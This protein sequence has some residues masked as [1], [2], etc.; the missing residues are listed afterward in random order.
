[1]AHITLRQL[2]FFCALAE[3]GSF[4]AAAKASH[5][6]QPTLSSAVKELEEAL[7]V[8]LA[9]RDSQGVRLTLT[10][11][12]VLEKARA[13]LDG[14]EE[15]FEVARGA[16]DALCGP[17][18][19]AGIPTIAPFVFAKM[20]SGARAACPDLNLTLHEDKTEAILEAL[21]GRRL[22]A[23]LIALPWNTEG[24][25]HLAVCDDELLLCA[26][27]DH[28]LMDKTP[29]ESGDV[30]L[31]H[32]LLLED[33][34]CLRRHALAVCDQARRGGVVG[35]TSLTT[36]INMVAERLGLT[37]LPR[38]AVENGLTI[39]NGVDVRPFTD[40]LVGRT[41]AVAWKKGSRAEAGARALAAVLRSALPAPSTHEPA[42]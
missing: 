20:L 15:V 29:L 11:E 21:R 34:H 24:L 39:R 38:I 28:P 17:F 4:S 18:R 31:R 16:G 8:Q 42:A 2:Q 6:T 10:G 12:A 13:V 7:G 36:L 5:V 19:L 37:L 40:P 26:P 33:G 32:L 27:A 14:V 1:M 41:I 23:G 22:D 9:E 35:A 25:D 30:D 3:T